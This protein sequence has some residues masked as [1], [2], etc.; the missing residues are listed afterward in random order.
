MAWLNPVWQQHRNSWDLSFFSLSLSSQ[1]FR[2]WFPEE[3]TGARHP[4]PTEA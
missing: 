1:F 4:V 2:F 3:L